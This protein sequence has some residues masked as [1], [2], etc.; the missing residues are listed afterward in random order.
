MHRHER[1]VRVYTRQQNEVTEAVPEL[2]EAALALPARAF[3]LD[4]E[5]I[6]LGRDQRPLPFQVTMRRFGRRLEVEALQRTLPLTGFFFDLLHLDGV[7]TM[8][9]PQSERSRALARLL[10]PLPARR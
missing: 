6:A 5:A 4:G 10:G 9:L 7:D 2:V 3:V 8:A 1:E